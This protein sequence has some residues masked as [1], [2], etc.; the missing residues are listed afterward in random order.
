MDGPG[1][2]GISDDVARWSQAI[3]TRAPAYRRLLQVLVAILEEG[4]PEGVHLAHRLNDAWSSRS[5]R[6]FYERP[7]L[8]LASLRFA[9]ITEGAGHPLWSAVGASDPDPESATRG[10]LLEALRAPSVWADIHDGFVQTNETSRAMAWLWP[11][12]IVGCSEGKRPLVL[13]EVGAAAGLNLVAD[14]LPAEWTAASGG[15]LVTTV[16][17]DVVTRVGIDAHPLDARVD[18]DTNWLRACVWAGERKRLARL[19]A[20]IEAFRSLPAKV[21]PGDVT[22]APE[23]LFAL[24]QAREERGVVVAFQTIVRDYLDDDT[25]AKYELG[26]KRWLEQAPAASALWIELEIDYRDS[27]NAV[28]V[29]VHVREDREVVDIVLGTTAFH[30]Q[31][32]AVNESAVARLGR[33]FP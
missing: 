7:L 19:E 15:R 31:S 6:I 20:A 8:L 3:G 5:F 32:V 22:L 27:G 2:L 1:G 17:P 18:R 23:R 25:R 26:M 9:A 24:S 4:S 30:P 13:F 12:A 21:E 16:A 28:P 11:A 33:M 29:V 10:A 14:R